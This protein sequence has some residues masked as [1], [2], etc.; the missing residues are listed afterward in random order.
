[1]NYPISTSSFKVRVALL[2]IALAGTIAAAQA[3]SSYALTKLS[4]P[5]L[6]KHDIHG[7]AG[8]IDSQ[9]RV[10]ATGR[11]VSGFTLYSWGQNPGF[12]YTNYVS[13]WPASTAA[14]VSP[15]KLI[16][17]A[18]SFSHQS[19][20]GSK[21][22]LILSAKP[23]HYYDTAKRQFVEV[24]APGNSA[25]WGVNAVN[26][27]GAMAGIDYDNQGIA[28][29]TGTRALRWT[30]GTAAP[31]V[32]PMGSE[33]DRSSASF[34]NREGDVVGKVEKVEARLSRAVVWRESGAFEVLN[35]EPDTFS[36]P[37]GVTDSGDVLIWKEKVGTSESIYALVSNG[38]TKT[39]AAPNPGDQL[40][41]I[42]INANGVVV[43]TVTQPSAPEGFR[44][45][46]FIWK[47]GVFT[48]LT[49]WVTAKGL[50]L[51]Q[52]AVISVAWQINAQGSILASLREANGTTSV[53]RLTA[54]P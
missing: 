50:K 9:N 4:E 25:H 22:F 38:V 39:I 36:S 15:S 21:I 32:L 52:G 6:G 19:P 20:D 14:S 47:D 53:V 45:R 3:Q 28:P 34:I 24:P 2:A 29:A 33:F 27:S 42:T 43:G 13:R 11:Y 44:E 8:Q 49:A 17:Q 5:F 7:N 1:M 41:R 51:P 18:G 10:T 12:T 31:E 26:D 46:G 23:G 54:K 16:T 35:N 30:P 37:L 40:S 48:D